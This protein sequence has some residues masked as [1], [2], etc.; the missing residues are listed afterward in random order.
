VDPETQVW[1][2]Y[3]AV[4]A[5]LERSFSAM[6]KRVAASSQPSEI[7]EG[8]IDAAL[9]Y[10]LGGVGGQGA[11]LLQDA[12]AAL[13]LGVAARTG[14]GPAP[15]SI[16]R[17]RRD[18]PMQL[19][20]DGSYVVDAMVLPHET[21]KPPRVDGE[22]IEEVLSGSLVKGAIAEFLVGEYFRKPPADDSEFQSRFEGAFSRACVVI[23]DPASLEGKL[24]ALEPED[25]AKMR[26]FVCFERL[27]NP[28]LFFDVEGR[29]IVF[30]TAIMTY[31]IIVISRASL[32][33]LVTK[34]RLARCLF[35][36]MRSILGLQNNIY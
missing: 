33:S 35:I 18:V 12:R 22:L 25:I 13:A 20:E 1:V 36:F 4:C 11:R 10:V 26:E 8:E 7:D 27:G 21:R 15:A 5:L 19:G 34:W 28:P 9:D 31:Y 24:N 14:S 29:A 16:T 6:R 2:T 17:A 3:G 23:I 30:F 32:K